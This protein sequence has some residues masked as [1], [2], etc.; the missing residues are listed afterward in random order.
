MIIVL[1]YTPKSLLRYREKMKKVEKKK[2]CLN[3]NKMTLSVVG[4]DLCD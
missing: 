4:L 1:W 3:I 2:D